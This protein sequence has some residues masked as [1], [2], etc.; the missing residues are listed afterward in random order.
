MKQS[1]PHDLS[2]DLAR[3]AAV[4]ALAD[5]AARFPAANIRATWSGPYA[6]TVALTV[7]GFTL[8]P[9]VAIRAGAID[10]DVDIPL[11]ARP[12]EGKARARIERE[13]AMWVERARTG[14]RG[15]AV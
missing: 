8:Q 15:A 13:L 4:A 14:Q 9:R 11:L 3:Q 2:L 5:Y 10:V 7:K 12:F 6:A 1:V